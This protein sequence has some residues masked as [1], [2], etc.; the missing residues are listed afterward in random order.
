MVAGEGT[1]ARVDPAHDMAMWKTTE[2]N[3]DMPSQNSEMPDHEKRMPPKQ[4]TTTST[5]L[6]GLLIATLVIIA[7]FILL[8]LMWP[9]SS[10]DF[11]EAMFESQVSANLVKSVQKL[12]QSFPSQTERFWKT[13]RVRSTKH[14][15]SPKRPLVFMIAADTQTA[16]T[17][18]CLA[19]HL[20][21]AANETN[22]LLINASEYT[23]EDG[24]QVKLT[25]DKTMKQYFDN[26]PNG[27]VVINHIELLPPLSPFLFYSYCDNDNA[28]YPHSTVIFIAHIT[29]DLSTLDPL[30]AEKA[31]EQFL[32]KKVW[33]NNPPYD[34]G[35]VGALLSRITDTVLVP[36]IESSMNVDPTLCSL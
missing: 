18:Q 33:G 22:P 23:V 36:R 15:T 5:I 30:G 14:I 11:S 31:V 32:G 4:Q 26:T 34:P 7:I 21:Q 24:D 6:N 9:G 12:K 10:V 1:Q 20:I 17:S 28:L 27:T 3:H 8:W 16:H 19:R 13:F 2:A 25:L 29:T 35:A